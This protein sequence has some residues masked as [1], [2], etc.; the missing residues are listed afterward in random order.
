MPFISEKAEKPDW[1][2][3]VVQEEVKKKKETC[4]RWK[5]SVGN[6]SP[7]QHYQLPK[8]QSRQC[9]DNAHEKWCESKAQ[10]AEKLQESAVR[11]GSVGSL[12]K[13]LRLLKRS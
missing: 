12:L 9:A 7:R 5:K 3:N 8:V 13:D 6:K 10:E 4:M 11:L 1:V 2:T